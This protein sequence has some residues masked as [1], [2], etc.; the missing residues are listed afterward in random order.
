MNRI[1]AIARNDLRLLR[2]DPAFLII[3]T[4]TPIAF[5]AFNESAIG[6][7]LGVRFP[8]AQVNGAAYVVPAATVIFSG[9]LVGNVGF[10]V[11][12]EHGWGTWE[13]LRASPLTPNELMLGK[14]VV[15]ILTI[16]FQI[17]VLLTAGFVLF[18]LDVRGSMVAFV[19]VALALAV[20][21]VALG[22]MLLSV[23]KSVIQLNALAT[24]GAMLIGGLGGALTPVE[25]LPGWAQA[26]APFTPAYW[27]MQGFREVTLKPGGM[28]DVAV[29][30]LVLA[31]FTAV[32]TVVAMVRFRVEDTKISWA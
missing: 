14:S 11:F 19:A 3:F 31:G 6:A 1:R 4:I 30:L 17:A 2:R 28:A 24:A 29:P 32:F 21:N 16:S 26:I 7:A 12:R 15:P 10:G 5:M 8:H 13:R 22:F 18:D 20:M 25:F 9:F 27:A 23:C